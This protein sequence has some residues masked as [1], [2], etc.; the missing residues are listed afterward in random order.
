MLTCKNGRISIKTTRVSRDYKRLQQTA[1]DYKRLMY[2]YSAV[3]LVHNTGLL[4]NGFYL[5]KL[6]YKTN[7][8]K[9]FFFVPVQ[10]VCLRIYKGLGESEKKSINN[11]LTQLITALE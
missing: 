2:L 11:N 10:A 5:S 7:F 4:D 8:K 9:L 6:F 3:H 1:R